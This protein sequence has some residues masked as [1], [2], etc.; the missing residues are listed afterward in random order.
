MT[1]TLLAFAYLLNAAIAAEW[2]FALHMAIE[3]GSIIEGKVSGVTKFGAFVD[4][5]EG[6]TGMV[7]ISEVSNDYVENIADY[8]KRGDTVKV[9]VLGV[10]EQGKI[11]LS[12]KKAQPRPQKEA[13]PQGE[14]SE[15]PVRKERPRTFQGGGFDAP[16]SD[17]P[18]SFEDMLKKF[19]KNSDEKLSDLKKNTSG[20]QGSMGYSRRSGRS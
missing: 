20:K 12:M 13:T 15:R 17:A 18:V 11:S 19:Q 5:G 2:K 4:L 10:N 3:I 6:Q 16:K 1:H 14:R 7:H 8:V 9:K